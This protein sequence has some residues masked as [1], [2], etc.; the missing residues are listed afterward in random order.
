MP[1]PEEE[2]DNQRQEG[3]HPAKSAEQD[4]LRHHRH[5]VRQHHRRQSNPKPEVAAREFD[6]GEAVTAQRR[7]YQDSNLVEDHDDHRVG[8]VLEKR[9]LGQSIHIIHPA[10]R[11]RNPLDGVLEYLRFNF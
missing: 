8:E 10:H 11:I 5:V 6:A 9:L 7:G 3:V 1:L 4:E 2:G